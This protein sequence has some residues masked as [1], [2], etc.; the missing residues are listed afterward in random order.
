M[1]IRILLQATLLLV[2][3]WTGQTSPQTTISDE[4]QTT[5]HGKD[6]EELDKWLNSPMDEARAG[7]L[8]ALV[9]QLNAPA[10]SE[11]ED[12]S[13]LLIEA[14]PE[15]FSALRDAYQSREAFETSMRI[16]EVV[17]E[18]YLKYYVYDRNAFLGI[19]QNLVPKEHHDDSRIA[20]DHIGIEVRSVIPKTSAEKAELKVGDVIIALD[21][22]SLTGSAREG[23]LAFGE[24]IRVRGPGTHLSLT[25]LRGP[26]ELQIDV[27][28]GTRPRVHYNIN[29]G[30]IFEMLEAARQGFARFWEKHFSTALKDT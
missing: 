3:A 9:D 15:A 22:E 8:S 28:L 1:M 20:V 2:G 18:I 21:N 24:S 16:E 13:A 10:Y 11:R 12:A 27:I 6:V 17:R 19:S 29:Q 5:E 4:L 30:P 25:V 7:E 23:V 14:G 26:K